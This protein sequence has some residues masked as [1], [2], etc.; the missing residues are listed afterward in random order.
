MSN[1]CVP[2]ITTLKP[3]SPTKTLKAS[4]VVDSQHFSNDTISIREIGYRN[5]KGLYNDLQ[6]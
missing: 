2:T 3:D 6:L 1:N 4:H 5:C